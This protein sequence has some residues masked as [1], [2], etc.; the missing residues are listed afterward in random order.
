[1]DGLDGLDAEMRS[2]E[3]RKGMGS[4]PASPLKLAATSEGGRD[5]NHYILVRFRD[6]GTLLH[7]TFPTP[8]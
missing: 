6:P 2:K 3:T 7:R 1:M 4:D 8:P 5:R